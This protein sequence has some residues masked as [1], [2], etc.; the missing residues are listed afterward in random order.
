MDLLP[1][2]SS[3]WMPVTL[4]TTEKKKKKMLFF[5]NRN[6]R[7]CFFAAR[8]CNVSR[9]LN[10]Q[11]AQKANRGRMTATLAAASRPS[12]PQSGHGK[13]SS[14]EEAATAAGDET[15]GDNKRGE[16]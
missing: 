16:S 1:E 6:A 10:H 8:K 4:T 15:P 5:L 11:R 3:Q 9:G 7:L 13:K 14:R 2:G 12:F